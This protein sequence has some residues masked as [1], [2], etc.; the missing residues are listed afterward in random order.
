E[1]ERSERALREGE[2]RLQRQNLALSELANERFIRY[3]RLGEAM[4]LLTARVAHTLEVARVGI[5]R[6]T[7]AKNQIECLHLYERDGDRHGG[8]G[9]ITMAE[10]PAYFAALRDGRVLAAEDARND[11]RTRELAAAYLEPLGVGAMLD[12][13]LRLG[14]SLVGVL[15]HEHVGPKR[16]WTVDE[17][18]FAGSVADLVSLTLEVWQHDRARMALARSEERYR[19]LVTAITHI[20]GVLSGTGQ[21]LER[22]ASWEVFTGQ[23]EEEAHGTGYLEAIHP[24]DRARVQAHIEEV[25]TGTPVLSETEFRVRRHD[26]IYRLLHYRAAPVREPDGAVREWMVAGIDVSE[27]REAERAVGEAQL[28][29]EARVAARTRELAAANERLKELDRLKSEFLATMSHELRTPLNSIIGFTGILRQGIA[30]TVNA[31]QHKQ[32]SMV[33]TSAKHLLGL[34]NDLLDLS[35]IESG[36][37]EVAF[38]LVAL[39]EVVTEVLQVLGPLAYQKH[40]GIAAEIPEGLPEVETDRKKLFQILLNLANNAVKF[41]ER[42]GVSITGRAAGGY[43]EVSVADTGIGIR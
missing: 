38:T 1:R 14:D 6:F 12:A 22:S 29:L 18:V 28:A 26:G 41:T 19:S 43:I 16:Q 2:V 13:P 9:V 5:W 33:Y 7:E 20:V 8:G 37:M 15:C 24:E 11:P 39:P 25:G 17:Q 21:L 4:R 35:R 34:I 30:G 31:E 3:R 10:C 42:G 27:V 36:R 40:I 23:G 32:L